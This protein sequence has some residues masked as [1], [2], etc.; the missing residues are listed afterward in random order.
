MFG[1][2][3]GHDGIKGTVRTRSGPQWPGPALRLPNFT[4]GQQGLCWVDI[5]AKGV[6]SIVDE[7]P[8]SHARPLAQIVSSNIVSHW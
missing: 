8:K 1:G 5:W 2:N 7:S 4:N 6:T 3:W